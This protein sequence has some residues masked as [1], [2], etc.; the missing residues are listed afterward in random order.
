MDYDLIPPVLRKNLSRK[1]NVS[2]QE[3]QQLMSV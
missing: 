2:H 3:T 1:I